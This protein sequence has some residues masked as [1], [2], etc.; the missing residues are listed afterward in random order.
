M[1]DSDERN[2]SN[3][4]VHEEQHT[5]RRGSFVPGEEETETHSQPQGSFADQNQAVDDAA[6]PPTVDP[7]GEDSER[8][9]R[10]SDGPDSESDYV[11]PSEPEGSFGTTDSE[12]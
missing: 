2:E 6:D 1:S 12:D 7:E 4:P 9:G 11:T 8:V 10:F 3:P 5:V